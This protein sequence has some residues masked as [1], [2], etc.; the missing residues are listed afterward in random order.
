MRRH[1]V[2]VMSSGQMLGNA[3]RSLGTAMTEAVTTY[4]S[5]QDMQTAQTIRN[6]ESD[7]E[8]T[9][10]VRAMRQGRAIDTLMVA[11]SAASGAVA[12][13]LLQRT[14]GNPSMYGVSPVGGLGLLTMLAGLAAPLGLP[15]RA[16]LVAGGATYL[17]GAQLYSHL[18]PKEPAP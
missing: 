9:D 5:G 16:A 4:Y 13:A 14:L 8:A 3:A 7:S 11:A 18:F 15:G 1:T 17:A 12:G 6:A 2:G 10:I